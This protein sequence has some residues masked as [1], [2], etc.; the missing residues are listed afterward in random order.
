IAVAETLEA[1]REAAGLVRVE[2]APEG[3]DVALTADHPKL[4]TPE[5]VNPN[6]PSETAEGDVDA[7]LARA[8]IVVDE[9]Y[10][11][12]AE[13]NN[14]ME[15][16]ATLAVWSGGDL[17]LYDSTQ[18]APRARDAIAGVFDL[19]PE[20]VRVI[21]PRVGG[22]CGSKGTPRP[23]VIAAAIAARHVDRPV[24]LTATRQQMF[25]FVGYR[26]PTIQRVRLGAGA[27]GRLVAID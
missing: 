2:Y 5:K 18:G 23:T 7:A 16:H 17:T 8:A 19:P 21:S 11:T 13:H 15:P 4:Y 9:T 25:T 12:P 1:A 26:T 22:G 20:R 10:T 27:D 24:K 14:P 6:F 3:H